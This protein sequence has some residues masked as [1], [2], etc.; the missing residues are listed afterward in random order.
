[1]ICL[2]L[3]SNI[4][5]KIPT[6]SVRNDTNHFIPLVIQWLPLEKAKHFG[7]EELFS[8]SMSFFVYSISMS[9]TG[10]ILKALFIVTFSPFDIK[11]IDTNEFTPCHK[12]IE[13]LKENI[14]K[15]S[16]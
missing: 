2:I 8:R 3:N 5:T 7:T 1:M 4:K 15:E 10:K 6:C 12:S 9:D 13:F 16:I 14:E 11:I